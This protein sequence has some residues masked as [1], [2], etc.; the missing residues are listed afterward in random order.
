MPDWW[1]NVVS[2]VIGVIAVVVFI[3]RLTS[4]MK[5]LCRTNRWT[6]AAEA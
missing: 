1:N 5:Y 6:R 2:P 3:G 4:M